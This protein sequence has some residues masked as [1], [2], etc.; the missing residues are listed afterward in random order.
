M[1]QLCFVLDLRTL[2]PPL[3]R[4]LKQVHTASSLN[5]NLC[6]LKHR[7]ISSFLIELGFLVLRSC[8]H[9]QSLLQLANFYVISSSSSSSHKSATLSD[10]IGLCYVVK[11]HL[12]SS[13]EV[14]F[15]F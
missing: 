5:L 8:F 2:A 1:V 14:I 9:F 12:S 6:S 3:L 11:N 10:K 15:Q 7:A 4:D 13:D